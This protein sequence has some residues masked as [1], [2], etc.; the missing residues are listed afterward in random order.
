MAKVKDPVV[1]D[2]HPTKELFINML[3]RDL[4][5]IDAI[6]DLVDNSV[7]A[8]LSL[9]TNRKFNGLFVHILVQPGHF[10]IK[11]NC[12]GI[13]RN[14]AANYA[15]RFGRHRNAKTVKGSVGQ[16]GIGMKRALFKL[17]KNFTIAS[18]TSKESFE[19]TINVEEWK[20]KENEWK[21]SF[22]TPKP[23][24]HLPAA[25]G[26]RITVNNLQDDVAIEFKQPE[27][28]VNKLISTLQYEHMFA[29]SQGLEIRVNSFR[30]KAPKL[31][32]LA[33]PNFATG[34]WEK[35]IGN[36]NVKVYAGISEPNSELGGWYIFCNQRLVLG[37]EQT[38]ITGW[39]T[40]QRGGT[41]SYHSQY[42]RF[43]GY[44]FFEA[45][46]A[47]ELPWNTTKTGMDL[48]SPL[49]KAVKHQMMKMM[50]PVISFC[51]KL[52]KEREKDNEFQPL[53]DL[54]AKLNLVNLDDYP[55]ESHAPAFNFPAVSATR[56][57]EAGRVTIQFVVDR[58][59]LEKAKEYLDVT[60]NWEVGSKAFEYFYSSE[61]GS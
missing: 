11:D 49:Y 10:S 24:S 26:T 54:T 6:G 34:F 52:K 56:I 43:R 5:L 23:Q 48:D 58:K 28:F 51:N 19:V 57:K 12:G 36:V 1:I 29:I 39:T 22:D 7:D 45:D 55:K 61:I 42:N 59:K 21:F 47:S 14:T 40:T 4:S 44:V 13:S 32:F 16:F 15:F 53:N 31:E 38:E 41:V 8:A 35:Q 9:H 30:L 27:T 20:R 60:T 3:V 17:G 37:P 25:I 33:G 50:K 18:T 2:A 46:N